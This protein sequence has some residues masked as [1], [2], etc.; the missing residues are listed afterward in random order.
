L[1]FLALDDLGWARPI[2]FNVRRLACR[3]FFSA[4]APRYKGPETQAE[5]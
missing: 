2:F 3:P 5:V 1:R 4:L